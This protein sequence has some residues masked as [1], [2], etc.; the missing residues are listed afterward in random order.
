MEASEVL[1]KVLR[2]YASGIGKSPRMRQ[3]QNKAKSG[4]LSFDEVQRAAGEAGKILGQALSAELSEYS[5]GAVLSLP[6]ALIVVPPSLRRNY[7]F[8]TTLIESVE[9]QGNLPVVAPKFDAERAANLAKHVASYDRFADHTADFE[10]L[11]ENNSRG[12]V[13]DAV[14]ST[15]DARYGMG[16]RPMIRRSQI[17]QCCSWCA[18]VAGEYEYSSRMDKSVFRRH[19]GCECLIELIR[20]GRREVVD[21]YTNW[22]KRN[23]QAELRQRIRLLEPDPDY[24]SPG[25]LIRRRQEGKNDPQNRGVIA[26]RILRGEYSLKYKHQKYL[27]HVQGTQQYEQATRLRNRQQ[28]Y[29]I[30]SEEEAQRLIYKLCG[31]GIP[32]TDQAGSIGSKEYVDAGR[33]I[34]YYSNREKVFEPTGRIA[35]HYSKG[36]AHIV[37]VNPAFGDD[38]HD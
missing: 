13:D 16:L 20:D 21:N 36:G 10:E 34:G 33:V 38:V 6:D 19:R 8:L 35:I 15:A 9:R 12:V 30:I 26:G 22:D 18:E 24:P 7:K 1:D 17:G 5:G 32:Y 27:Q 14:R 23:D 11:V 37:P 28:S 25:E 31:K 3:L 2:R 4:G 29:L